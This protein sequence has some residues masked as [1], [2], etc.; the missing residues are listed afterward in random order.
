M[1]VDDIIPEH[2]QLALAEG[3]ARL[4]RLSTLDADR[5]FESLAWLAGYRPAIF[6]TTLNATEPCT[7]D[8][9]PDPA[10]NPEPYCTICGADVG[11]FLRFGLDWRHYRGDG[12]VS[13]I[14]LFEADHAPVIAWRLASAS[15]EPKAR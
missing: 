8:D 13:Q 2:A 6:D 14:E 12:T 1:T 15:S 9:S 10:E 5:M 7:S 3:R 11:I 4:D